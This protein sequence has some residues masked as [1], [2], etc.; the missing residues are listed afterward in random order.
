[1]GNAHFDTLPEA[2]REAASVA[3]RNVLGSVPIDAVTPLKGGA[4]AA[5]ILRIDAGTRHYLMRV[6]GPPSP[7]RNPHQYV[8]LRIAADAGIA[9]RLYYAD[10]VARIAV[11]DF[12]EQRS[13]GEYPGGPFA[14]AQSVGELVRR[15]QSTEPFPYFVDY[16]DIVARLWAHVCRTDLFAPDVLDPA[17]ER[18]A[19][20]REAYVWDRAASVSSHNDPIPANILFDGRRL[21]LVDWESAYRND[22]LVDVAIVLDNLAHTGELEAALL[23]AWLGRPP[24][25]EPRARLNLTR[26]LTRLYYAGVFFSAS[27]TFPRAASDTDLTAPTRSEFLRALGDGRLK[28]GTGQ[29]KHVLGKMFL[30]AFMTGAPTPGFDAAV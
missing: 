11:M 22:P 18:F 2:R 6:E 10:E 16:S 4:T 27:A 8:S 17:N 15:L 29:T 7:L 14:L 24:G 19:E 9:P 26:A 3:L 12:V 28:P 20:L 13:L 21:W 5:A 30:A 23:R 1:M 25:D